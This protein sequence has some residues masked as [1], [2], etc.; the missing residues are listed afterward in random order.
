MPRNQ[1]AAGLIRD[2]GNPYGLMS[3]ISLFAS[4]NILVRNVWVGYF[5]A[6]DD[7]KAEIGVL[8]CEGTKI[9]LIAIDKGSLQSKSLARQCKLHALQ[10]AVSREIAVGFLIERDAPADVFNSLYF[11]PEIREQTRLLITDRDMGSLRMQF[12][13]LSPD[14]V[15]KTTTAAAVISEL[16]CGIVLA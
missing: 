15:V 1:L 4:H 7:K 5:S 14:Y 3:K 11:V 10:V 2:T 6:T 16:V 8:L 12:S 13:R 9:V